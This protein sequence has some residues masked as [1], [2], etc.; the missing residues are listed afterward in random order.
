MPAAPAQP[1]RAGPYAL[2]Q[3]LGSG[4]ESLVWLAAHTVDRTPAV[5]KVQRA[6]VPTSRMRREVAVLYA[7]Q[8]VKT[9]G[10]VRLLPA[11]AD[12]V[13]SREPGV[14][15][16]GTGEELLYFVMER[17]PAEAN[18]N[19]IKQLPLKKSD[20]RDVCFGVSAALRVMHLFFQVVHNDLKPDNILAWRDPRGGLQ[21]R[22]LDFGQAALL[23]PH[24]RWS[25]PCITPEPQFR[26]VYVYGS[27]PYMAPERWHGQV[28]YDRPDASGQWSPEAV[29]DER[30]EQWSFGATVFELLTGQR[31]V[32][33]GSDEQCRRIIVN[34]DYLSAVRDA[35]LPAAVKAVLSRALAVNPEQRYLPSPSVSG[36]DF[37]CRDLEDALA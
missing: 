20:V 9:P 6:D 5:V 4:G 10:V 22:L 35:K 3:Q 13:V 27:K 37:F 18:R 23:S 29:V 28:V 12:S 1:P 2:E 24:P 11:G 33:S 7:L 8:E 25:L 14:M 17:L 19:V 32:N 26:Y 16:T 21:V 36:L 15:H 34:G 31:L 30:C